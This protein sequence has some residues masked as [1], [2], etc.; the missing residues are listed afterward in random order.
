MIVGRFS[1]RSHV[2]CGTI[3]GDNKTVGPGGAG[4]TV[5]R[6]LTLGKEG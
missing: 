6:G 1:S 2:R 3:E 4:N 5:T